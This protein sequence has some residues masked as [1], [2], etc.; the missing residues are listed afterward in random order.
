MVNYYDDELE[1]ELEKVV[2]ELIEDVICRN[3][4]YDA[5][6]IYNF[7]ELTEEQRMRLEPIL[8]AA[9]ILGIDPTSLQKR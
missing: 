6:V 8:V 7:L 9:R 1:D 5:M 4:Y 3:N 2:N